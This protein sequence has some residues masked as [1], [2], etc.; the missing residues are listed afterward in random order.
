MKATQRAGRQLR[1]LRTNTGLSPEALGARIGVSGMTIRRIER[2]EC[3]PTVR[4][5][6][7][8]AAEFEMR[9]TDMWP[10]EDRLVAR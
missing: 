6:F 2:G 5:M 4:T 10:I 3:H 1:E 8:L 9:P 7:L